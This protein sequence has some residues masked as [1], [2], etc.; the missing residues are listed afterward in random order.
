MRSS[1][2]IE[3]VLPLIDQARFGQEHLKEM[4]TIEISRLILAEYGYITT[5]QSRNSVK[6]KTN[7]VGARMH[8]PECGFIPSECVELDVTSAFPSSA[9]SIPEE[10]AKQIPGATTV[11]KIMHQWITLRD[12]ASADNHTA[13]AKGFKL[14]SN[15]FIGT[16]KYIL[17]NVRDYIVTRLNTHI[18]ALQD[19][20]NT[21]KR[22]G[23][24][25]DKSEIPRLRVI[26]VTF[27]SLTVTVS[28]QRED[29]GD[30]R[31]DHADIDHVIKTSLD[32]S[33]GAF[34]L[35]LDHAFICMILSRKYELGLIRRPD[36][37]TC[38]R[39]HQRSIPHI[40]VNS[41]HESVRETTY[42]IILREFRK[43]VEQYAHASKNDHI[44]VESGLRS[45]EEYDSDILAST[46]CVYKD[47]T[48]SHEE[49]TKIT[50]EL[51]SIA[52]AIAPGYMLTKR[53]T[54]KKKKK[55]Y[56]RY[57]WRHRRPR[58]NTQRVH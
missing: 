27:D 14:C 15:T 44:L 30:L 24:D 54:T 50:T 21:W 29:R 17:P 49:C 28:K 55:N 5:T 48:E 10:D 25:E 9:V 56:L 43:R 19:Y 11:K 7:G 34:S 37:Y 41:N 1:Y 22:T 38:K 45:I 36:T 6:R 31:L 4:N 13:D 58:N 3:H 46:Q 12:K 39:I 33:H 20:I 57:M 42:A 35:R 53:T 26:R 51:Q 16:L 40:L 47:T 8:K 32:I 52:N 18:D 23:D 2:T